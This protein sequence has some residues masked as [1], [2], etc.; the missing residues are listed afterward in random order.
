MKLVNMPVRYNGVYKLLLRSYLDN[1]SQIF[2]V[3]VLFV[4]ISCY[5]TIKL[6][7]ETATFIYWGSIYLY[8]IWL[9]KYIFIFENSRAITNAEESV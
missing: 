1:L 5:A 3:V 2:I 4:V 8:Q 6:I 9:L 7:F